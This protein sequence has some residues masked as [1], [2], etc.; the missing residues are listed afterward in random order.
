MLVITLIK[1]HKCERF[2]DKLQLIKLDGNFGCYTTPSDKLYEEGKFFLIHVT[3][4]YYLRCS[5][6]RS[7]CGVTFI[8]NLLY[9]F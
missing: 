5:L 1:I 7:S 2:V 6:T 9:K 3:N 8:S 4:V